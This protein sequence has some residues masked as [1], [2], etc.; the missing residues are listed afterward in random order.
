MPS[1]A[2]DTRKNLSGYQKRKEIVKRSPEK[3]LVL[4]L[5]KVVLMATKGMTAVVVDTVIVK[6]GAIS[7]AKFVEKALYDPLSGTVVAAGIQNVGTLR[8][9]VLFMIANRV[10]IESSSVQKKAAAPRRF[11]RIIAGVQIDQSPFLLIEAV[12]LDLFYDALR[13]PRPLVPDETTEL[14]LDSE[15][16]SLHTCVTP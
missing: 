10:D 1:D 5:D 4:H 2:T 11:K 12:V 14:R 7:E 8:G 16:A 3:V 9:R 13:R 15:D 6:G